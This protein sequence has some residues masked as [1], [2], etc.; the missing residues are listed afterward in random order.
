MPHPPP[1][2]GPRPLALHLVLQTL[3]LGPWMG[4]SWPNGWTPWNVAWPF[5]KPL[6]EACWPNFTADL[7]A[8]PALPAALSREAATRL[9]AFL[10]GVEAYHAHPYR[11]A[12]PD[13]PPFWQAGTTMLR[14]YAPEAGPQARPVLLVP[15]LINRAHILDL[16]SGRSL[17]RALAEAGLRP[18]LLDWDTPG[19][20]EARFTLDDYV[21]RRLIPALAA[22]QTLTLRPP[23]VLGYCMGGLLALALAACRPVAGLALLATPWDFHAADT[24]LF[25]LVRAFLPALAA[26]SAT[27]PVP[28]DLL[29]APFILADP[30][31]V[32]R[33]YASFGRL[34]PAS[35]RAQ[36]FVAIE[37]WLNDGVDLATP[38]AHDIAR[39]WLT[40][41]APA[42]GTWTVQGHVVRPPHAP[43]LL[44]QGTRD[45]L[46]PQT[47]SAP[48]RRFLPDA[49]AHDLPQGHVG[50]VAGREAPAS[51]YPLVIEWLHALS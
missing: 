1:R 50:L 14:D 46:V 43:A 8:W 49:R 27:R 7:P 4:A 17:C 42:C 30:G 22:L 45:T 16:A 51:L 12:L 18:V 33:R 11:R 26:G 5:W 35:A 23:A 19:P 2:L 13:P 15:S 41:N 21:T 39:L 29:Q 47:S 32:A 37:D 44:I 24:P 34:D 3:T 36:D 20:E 48:L 25:R 10:S 28:A 31:A 40:A 9:N 38:T 6:W